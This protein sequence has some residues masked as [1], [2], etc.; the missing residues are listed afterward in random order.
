MTRLPSHQF[1]PQT[2]ECDSAKSLRENVTELLCG[3]N[4]CEDYFSRFQLL[5][6]PVIFDSVVLRARLHS[7]RLKLTKKQGSNVI[8][9]DANME[10]RLVLERQ[11]KER[12][13]L[14][15]DVHGGKEILAGRAE[16]N[17]L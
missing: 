15:Y 7:T 11:V 3:F 8:L 17:I 1:L 4:F 12:A 10:S 9:V 16:G 6:K 5:T 13:N 2:L 14:L